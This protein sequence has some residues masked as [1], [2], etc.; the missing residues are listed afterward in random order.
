MEEEMKVQ[1]NFFIGFFVVVGIVATLAYRIIIIL[2]FYSSIW[3]KISWYIGTVGFILYFGYLYNVQSKRARLA[4]DYHLLSAIDKTKIKGKQKQ[5]LRYIVKSNVNSKTKWN[6]A[7][8]FILSVMA[9]VI[10]VIL[11]IWTF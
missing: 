6:S 11:D 9:L 5:A 3:V 1:S 8:I 4:V 7:A 2:N 10:G